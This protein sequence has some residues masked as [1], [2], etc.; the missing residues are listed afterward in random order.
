M[1]KIRKHIPNFLTLCNLLSGTIGIVTVFEGSLIYGA[2]FIWL[3]AVF[4]FLDGFSARLFNAYSDIGKELD[5]LADMVTFGVLPSL[6]VY[7]FLSGYFP[8]DSFWP[9]ISIIPVLFSAL[10]LAKFNIDT[11]QK[12]IF[13]GLP[14]PANAFLLSG[15]PFISHLRLFHFI[16]PPFYTI[17]TVLIASLLMVSSV[18]FISLK[19]KNLKFRENRYK[20]TI[21]F[22]GIIFISILKTEGIS[23][24]IIA[25]VFISIIKNL[26]NNQTNTP[27]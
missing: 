22:A 8:I 12:E 24:A 15:L 2:Y 26:S 9:Y 21:I 14:T 19:F 25:Y 13:I 17:P 6:T 1:I 11:K 3:G 27:L 16:S 10:R 5:S 7:R 18:E 23:I 20:F 4:D